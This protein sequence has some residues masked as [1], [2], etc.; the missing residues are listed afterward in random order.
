MDRDYAAKTAYAQNE[1]QKGCGNVGMEGAAMSAIGKIK[2]SE[3]SR[4]VDR[5]A[6]TLEKLS[7]VSSRL[8]ERVQSVTR[9]EPETTGALKGAN[10]VCSTDLGRK[11]DNL[12][13]QASTTLY[14]LQSLGERIEL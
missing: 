9:A 11:L 10:P 4:E 8:I 5:L 3:V 7:F 1:P 12:T 6:S 13:T 2:Q 14:R